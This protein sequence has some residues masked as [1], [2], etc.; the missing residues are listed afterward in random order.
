MLRVFLLV[1]VFHFALINAEYYGAPRCD[2]KNCRD[3]YADC[4]RFAKINC[5]VCPPGFYGGGGEKC[6]SKRAVERF[7]RMRGMLSVK[8]AGVNY[9]DNFPIS[10]ETITVRGPPLGQTSVRDVPSTGAMH[11]TIRLLTPLFHIINSITSFP[12]ENSRIYN[13]FSLSG[14][15]SA[16]TH[17]KFTINYE[18]LGVLSADV[19]L[20]RDI[21]DSDYYEGKMDIEVKNVGV[22]DV[23]R[24]VYTEKVFGDGMV[25]YSK[26]A[27]GVLRFERQQIQFSTMLED[28]SRSL[29]GSIVGTA[30][31]PVDETSC[32]LERNSLVEEN[33]DGF[34]VRLGGKGFCNTDCPNRSSFCTVYCLDY[35]VLE[36]RR[37]L[38]TEPEGFR[39]PRSI[40]EEVTEEGENESDLNPES[41][42]S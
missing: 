39:K 9:E 1:L 29:R 32:L 41:E 19:R 28:P 30:Q 31:V 42:N 12:N 5:C 27:R 34:R 35:P 7:I 14:G 36:S 33:S 23:P 38:Y 40:E 21:S 25:N 17:I 37:R 15:F 16:P 26:I 4:Y 6:T 20:Q 18:R 10:H 8:L 11:N 13:I 2:V 3:A 22:F 24:E